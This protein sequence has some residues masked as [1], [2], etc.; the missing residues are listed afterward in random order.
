[1][2]RRAALLVLAL[3]LTHFSGVARTDEPQERTFT[4]PKKAGPDFLVQGEYEGK[5]GADTVVGIQVIA[6]GDGKFDAVLYHKGLPGAGGDKARLPLK[7]ETTDGVTTLAG[8]KFAGI[9][10]NGSFTG[11]LDG[12]ELKLKRV[13]RQSP[14]IGAKPPAGAIILFDGKNADEWANGRIQEE[15]LLG[16]GTRTKRAFKNYTLH[17]EFRTPFMPYARGQGRGNSGLYL[18]DQYE[19]QI[20]DSFG[21]VGENNECGGYYSFSKPALNMCLPPLAWQTYDV[22]FTMAKFDAEGKKTAPA[23]ATVR[24]NGVIVHD[25]YEIPKINGGGGLNDESKPGPIFVQ[26][27]GNPVHFR[28]VW[29]LEKN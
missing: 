20:L 3:G 25:K 1:M 10:K 18:N 14:T 27:H 17:I 6:L 22:D 15:Q 5:V 8:E 24:L 29:I 16:V 11:S 7:C 26:D 2:L 13:E 21:L 12:A 28:N 23:I 4:D 19:F 9:I